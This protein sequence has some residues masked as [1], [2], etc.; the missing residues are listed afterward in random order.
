MGLLDRV[1]IGLCFAPIGWVGWW[2]GR[3][4]KDR[5]TRGSEAV[6]GT[7][8]VGWMGALFDA[9]R[10]A[11]NCRKSLEKRMGQ[12]TIQQ[13]SDKRCEETLI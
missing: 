1:V 9:I 8:I 3:H 12:S 13:Q 4:Q 10:L 5:E 6:S 7:Q 11:L 2:Y